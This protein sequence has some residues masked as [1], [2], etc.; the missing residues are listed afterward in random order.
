MR[1]LLFFATLALA[2]TGCVKEGEQSSFDE[3]FSMRSHGQDFNTAI[4]V[5]T[6]TQTGQEYLLVKSGYGCG[7]SP[8]QTQK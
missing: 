7:L 4:F 5:I 6:D 1:K 8:M 3:R 2:L